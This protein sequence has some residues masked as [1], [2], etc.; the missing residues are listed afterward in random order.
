MNA[1]ELT[2]LALAGLADRGVNALVGSGTL[3]TFPVLLRLRL[4]GGP[5]NHL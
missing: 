5:A 2:A 4:L 3:I 1:V